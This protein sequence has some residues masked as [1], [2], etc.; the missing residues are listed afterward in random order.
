MKNSI[1]LNLDVTN[2]TILPSIF[3]FFLIIDLYCLIPAVIAQVFNRI[4]ELVIPIEIPIREGKA[5][6][7]MHPVIVGAKIRKCLI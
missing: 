4:A 3:S 1:L 6:I 7:K 5:E 2:N